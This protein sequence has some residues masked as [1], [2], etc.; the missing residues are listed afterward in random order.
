MA[1][2]ILAETVFLFICFRSDPERKFMCSG[3]LGNAYV[4]SFWKCIYFSSAATAPRQNV[5]KFIWHQFHVHHFHTIEYNVVK[6]HTN[7]RLPCLITIKET[8]FFFFFFSLFVQRKMVCIPNEK[9]ID[10]EERKQLMLPVLANGE[11]KRQCAKWKLK[12]RKEF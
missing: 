7:L 1:C 10:E 8:V 12:H 3:K 2:Y 5:L 11:H 4:P 9:T 6:K